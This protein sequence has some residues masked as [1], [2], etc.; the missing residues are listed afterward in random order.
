MALCHHFVVELNGNEPGQ[1]YEW[2]VV[3]QGGGWF[4]RS[5][6]LIRFGTEV[7]EIVHVGDESHHK[8]KCE[9]A[10][11]KGIY[12]QCPPIKL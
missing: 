7:G 2:L 11:T 10:Y 4:R 3:T 5:L 9:T 12:V 8:P 6:L 1:E